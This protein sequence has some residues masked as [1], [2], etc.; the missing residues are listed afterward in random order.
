MTGAPAPAGATALGGLE[1]PPSSVQSHRSLGG[2]GAG[3]QPRAAARPTSL[4]ASSTR[5]AGLT[6]LGD[7]LV[8]ERIDLR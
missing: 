7:V 6:V 1:F 5:R 4:R 3:A 2:Y 8:G